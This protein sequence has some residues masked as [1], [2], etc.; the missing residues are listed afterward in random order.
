V[1]TKKEKENST[2]FVFR[3]ADITLCAKFPIESAA[4]AAEAVATSRC[5]LGYSAPPTR[6]RARLYKASDPEV[7]TAPSCIRV[8]KFAA[9]VWGSVCAAFDLGRLSVVVRPRG[10][11]STPGVLVPWEFGPW[12]IANERQFLAEVDLRRETAVHRGQPRTLH[13]YW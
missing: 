12:V 1:K 7:R 10:W 3:A 11:R 13:H 6:P 9:G 8:V 2:R 4:L 5:D